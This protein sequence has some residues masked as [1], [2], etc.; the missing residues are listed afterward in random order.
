VSVKHDTVD[1]RTVDPR[2]VT[3][4]PSLRRVRQELEEWREHGD[5]Q[6]EQRVGEKVVAHSVPHTPV[7]VNTINL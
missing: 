5:V 1:E 4:P 7:S 6:I 2:A 3:A